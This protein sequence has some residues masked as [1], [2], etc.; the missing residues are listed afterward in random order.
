MINLFFFS[1]VGNVTPQA[2]F[3]F[4]ADPESVHIFLA[5]NVKPHLLLPWEACIK[6]KIPRVSDF[7]TLYS[8]R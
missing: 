8:H 1:A 6:S 2:E 7:I 4:F 3:N 5:N